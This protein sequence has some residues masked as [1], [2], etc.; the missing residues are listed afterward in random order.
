MVALTF[1]SLCCS[2]SRVKLITC[3]CG[4]ASLSGFL[5]GYSMAASSIMITSDTFI[6]H[7]CVDVY[8]DAESCYSNDL[9]AQPDGWI[10]YTT[11]FTAMLGLGSLVG[12]A[13]SAWA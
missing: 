7:F 13:L 11:Q 2:I 12:A 3:I 1:E 9:T 6:Q 5:Y 4:T 10:T 8:G